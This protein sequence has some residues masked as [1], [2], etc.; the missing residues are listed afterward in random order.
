[1][2]QPDS[3]EMGMSHEARLAKLKLM[4]AKR[5]GQPNFAENVAAIGAEIARL[6]ARIAA[7]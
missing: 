6:E 5:D 2:G 1:M 7:S 3:K 4:L